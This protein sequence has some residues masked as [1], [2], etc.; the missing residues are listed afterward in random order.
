MAKWFY[1]KAKWREQSENGK[2][3]SKTIELLIDAMSFTEAEARLI[4]SLETQAPSA[5]VSQIKPANICDIF[6]YDDCD[7]WYCTRVNYVSIDEKTG[8]E[9]VVP[10][11]MY[12]TANSV[13][14]ACERIEESLSTM[15]VPFEIM[16]VRKTK[17]AGVLPYANSI[18]EKPA[19]SAFVK[20]ADEL[21]EKGIEVTYTPAEV[22]E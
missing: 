20:L 6:H 17:I 16:E 21:R 1:T 8:R 22:V 11:T 18:E 14:K 4:T 12:V 5:M 10:N 7:V 2:V 3:V 19:T 13:V 15:I 9:I